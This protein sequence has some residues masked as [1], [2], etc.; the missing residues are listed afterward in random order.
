MVCCSQWGEVGESN[1]LDIAAGLGLPKSIYNAARL[2]MEEE[3]THANTV[4]QTGALLVRDETNPMVQSTLSNLWHQHGTETN[5]RAAV[6]APAF[7]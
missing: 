6:I 1:A 5:S 4:E 7:L 2:T 3:V